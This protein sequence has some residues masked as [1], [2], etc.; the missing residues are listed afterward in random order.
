MNIVHHYSVITH[1]NTRVSF[2]CSAQGYPLVYFRKWNASN[3]ESF[4]STREDLFNLRAGE[5]FLQVF[6]TEVDPLDCVRTGGYSCEFASGP[7]VY[8]NSVSAY[9]RCPVGEQKECCSY[10]YL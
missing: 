2:V 5:K 4:N 8:H 6:L 1:S 9:I 7:T 10:L 3:D